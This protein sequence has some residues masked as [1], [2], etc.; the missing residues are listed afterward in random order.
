[1]L[2]QAEEQIAEA[3]KSIEFLEAN[4]KKV[5]FVTNTS[6]RT[7]ADLVVKMQGMGFR[8]PKESHIYTM[9]QVSAR[10]IKRQYPN[11]RKVF[12]IGMPSMR[13]SL[14]AEGL[15]VIGADEDVLPSSEEF[16]QAT[17]DSYEID[18]DVGAVVYGIDFGF[19]H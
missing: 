19:T 4:D 10:Y 9:S 15:E 7:P 1:M 12:A 5:F 13:Q 8:E 14:E 11:V 3:F 2:W 18:R 16:D 6:S 17:F